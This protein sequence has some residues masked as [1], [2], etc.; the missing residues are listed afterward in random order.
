MT[1]SSQLSD[2]GFRS[3]LRLSSSQAPSRSGGSR[4]CSSSRRNFFYKIST[5]V[6]PG[7]I[8]LKFIII[9]SSNLNLDANFAVGIFDYTNLEDPLIESFFQNN[10]QYNNRSMHYYSFASGDGFLMIYMK[11]GAPPIPTEKKNHARL[12][13]NRVLFHAKMKCT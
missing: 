2:A 12:F 5:S 10:P 11:F 4:R 8:A 3:Y 1:F 13:E 6:V 7:K 9:Y